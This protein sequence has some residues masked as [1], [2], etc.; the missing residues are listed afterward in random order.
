MYNRKRILLRME[1][2]RNASLINKI[3]V[4]TKK[5]VPILKK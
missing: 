3:L 5:K 1:P 2:L 4:Q